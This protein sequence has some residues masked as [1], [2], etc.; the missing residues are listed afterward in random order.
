M[1]EDIQLYKQALRLAY[2]GTLREAQELL[3]SAI[4]LRDDQASYHSLLAVIY[5][6]RGKK[7]KAREHFRRAYELDEH[8][9][10]LQ[11]HLEFMRT[12]EE[13]WSDLR[14]PKAQSIS[15]RLDG[16]DDLAAL[17]AALAQIDTTSAEK[18]RFKLK[19]VLKSPKLHQPFLDW[20]DTFCLEHAKAFFWRFQQADPASVGAQAKI[21]WALNFMDLEHDFFSFKLVARIPALRQQ[22]KRGTPAREATNLIAELEQDAAFTTI[23]PFMLPFN[24]VLPTLTEILPEPLYDN[25]VKLRWLEAICSHKQYYLPF[26]KEICQLTGETSPPEAAIAFVETLQFDADQK[27]QAFN[28]LTSLFHRCEYIPFE[29]RDLAEGIPLSQPTPLSLELVDSA[30][31]TQANDLL[32]LQVIVLS[33]KLINQFIDSVDAWLPRPIPFQIKL[34]RFLTQPKPPSNFDAATQFEFEYSGSQPL[35][36]TSAKTKDVAFFMTYSFTERKYSDVLCG[37]CWEDFHQQNNLA[38]ETP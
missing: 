21:D 30:L 13:D 12:G 34:A 25:E 5:M 27:P 23:D 9:P 32:R 6:G 8:D 7:E 37:R 20:I 4:A 10:L 33:Q 28:W 2:D 26:L 11:P 15:L 14:A 36:D 22:F 3:Q 24:R 17:D 29:L 19:A 18:W 35:L 16:I 1:S 38:K 31:G